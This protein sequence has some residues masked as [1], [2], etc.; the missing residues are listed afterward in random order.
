MSADASELVQLVVFGGRGELARRKLIPAFA[1]LARELAREGTELMLVAVGRAEAD[2]ASFREESTAAL[3]ADG[4]R[5]SSSLFY[6][7]ADVRDGASLGRLARE[8]AHL[9]GDRPGGRLFYLALA[10]DLFE[11]AALGLAQAG[12][13]SPPGPNAS[14]WERVVVEKPFGTDLASAARLDWAMRTHLREEQIFRIDHFLAKETVQNL[15]GFRFHNSIFEPL[16]NRQHVEWVQITVADEDGVGNGRGSYYDSAGALRDVVQNHLLQILALVAMEP[17]PSLDAEAVRD[18][19]VQALRA[20]RRPAPGETAKVC[21]RAQYGAAPLVRAYR[22]ETGVAP[23]SQTETFVAVR[24]ELENWRWSGV[25]FLLRHGKRMPKRFTEVRI[26]FRVP[27]VQLFNRPKGMSDA[28]VRRRVADGSLCRVRPNALVLHLQPR[29]A[30]TL[31]FGVKEPGLAMRMTPAALEFDYAERFG[32]RTPDAYERLLLDA[33]RGDPSLFLRDDEV[34][35]AWEWTD[36]IRAGWAIG[37]GPPLLEYAARTWG[38]PE[39]DALLHGCCEGA[40]SRG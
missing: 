38:P 39:A 32:V 16:W 20:L 22:E 28:D 25:P 12:L 2:D 1:T 36:A 34:R 11:P 9:R 30:V 8:L 3:G 6:R 35:A 13:L 7:R 26:Q 21:V 24:A 14:M 17:P 10:P 4:A 29:E 37:T 19:K 18:Q 27:P 15:I 5:A 33:I 31:S 40:W 23:D